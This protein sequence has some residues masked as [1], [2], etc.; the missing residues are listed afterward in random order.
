MF[1]VSFFILTPSPLTQSEGWTKNFRAGFDFFCATSLKHWVPSIPSLTLL[2]SFLS[3]ISV[4]RFGLSDGGSFSATIQG[5]FLKFLHL[6]VR[7]FVSPQ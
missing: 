2:H 7:L 1:T 4:N 6:C 3:G 5:K